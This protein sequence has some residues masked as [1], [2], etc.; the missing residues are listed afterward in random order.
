MHTSKPTIGILFGGC[1]SEYDVSLQS[2]RSVIDS[3]DTSRFYAVP[4]GIARNGSWF[5][6]SGPA[7]A[8]ADD[9]WLDP[10]HCKQLAFAFGK[11]AR[12]LFELASGEKL[13][14]DAALPILHGRNGEDGSV[15]G[16]LQLA[17]I[18]VA[19]CGVA[20]SA[21]CI[22]KV[23]AHRIAVAEGI[24]VARSTVIDAESGSEALQDAAA[25][26]GYPLFVKPSREGSSMGLAR[27]TCPSELERAV[28]HARSFNC[29]VM[30]ER[31]VTGIEI[32][33]AVLECGGDLI[34]GVPDEIELN[35]AVFDYRE[36]YSCET[37]SIVV[38]ARI[39]A[40]DKLRVSDSAKKLFYALG[41]TGFARIDFFLAEDGRL[42]FNEANTI[43]G[44]TAH[45][46][47]PT[48]LEAIGIPLADVLTIA[49]T[50]ALAKTASE[51]PIGARMSAHA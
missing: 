50:E 34:V 7:S 19:G 48:M 23:L 40:H 45:S 39:S 14:L 28:D 8:I 18:P 29:E 35:G 30:L 4:I 42:Y 3:L 6:Y 20:G 22:D 21:T 47:F 38:P 24:C 41:C 9:T 2:A 26:I 16:V 11:H 33:C 5:A 27:V 25:R 51:N 13:H 17:G 37:A 32:G 46:R 43:P 44:F 12:G 1:S 31:E 49:I 15:Q 10:R 36:K